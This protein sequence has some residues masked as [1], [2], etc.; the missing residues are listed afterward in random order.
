[1]L[2]TLERFFRETAPVR[3]GDKVLVAFSAGPDS[4]ALL[5]GLHRLRATLGVELE[6]A[7]L[8]HG[9]DAGSAARATAATR[10]CETLSVPLSSARS[11]VAAG[12]RPGE[13]LEAAA[14]RVRYDFLEDVRRERGARYL[15]TGHQR[16]D[17]VETVLL[18]LAYG[19]GLAGLSGIAPVH[20]SVVRPLLQVDRDAVTA[21]LQR[22]GLQPALD[23]GNLDPAVPRNRVRHLLLPRL[24]QD[25]PEVDG[26]V[27]RLARAA[28]GARRALDRR[29]GQWLHPRSE[30]RGASLSL[31]PLLG[32]PDELW[33]F[34]LALL[35]RTA[36]LPYPPRAAATADLQRRLRADGGVGCDCG[37][38][39]R[40]SVRG[41]RLELT[42]EPRAAAGPTP[43]FAYTLSVPGEVTL[44][45]ISTRFRI[46]RDR[47]APWV[48]RGAARR[49][50]LA[51]EL[52]DGDC[53]TLRNRRP[54][55]RVRP[56]GC[57]YDRKLKEVLID[58]GIPRG[59]R[60]RIPLLCVGERIVWVPGVTIDDRCR[61]EDEED[62]WTVELEPLRDPQVP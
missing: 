16:D 41:D 6:A 22:S 14:R 1:M 9:L 38:G 54:G 24:R 46:R 58:R 27:V 61:I 59:E 44:E 29:L 62:A 12:R 33:P 37:S 2:D 60:D 51:L 49:A 36:G 13:S 47:V 7:H 26:L 56:L 48:F 15:A 32:L 53:A 10:T 11:A 5:W 50:G 18:R 17:Q 52:R 25:A 4:T 42:P 30:S 8:D 43:P 39:W 55:D 3:Q 40:W 28:A 57:S 20:G 34:A 35:H 23:P 45:E 21:A 19:S 31:K